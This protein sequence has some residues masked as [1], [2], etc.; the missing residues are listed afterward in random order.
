MSCNGCRALRKGCSQSCIL[1]PCLDWIDSPQAQS[2]ATL[3]V[4]KFF[5]RSDL[6][7]FIA[8]VPEKN[9]P[10]LFQSLLF[11]ACGRT[12][13]PVNGALGLLSTANWNICQIAVNTVLSGGT[14]RPVSA[15]ILT[16]Q[17]AEASDA[18]RSATK[19]YNNNSTTKQSDLEKNEI[20]ISFNSDLEESGSMISFDSG[21]DYDMKN[22]RG[23]EEPKLLNLFA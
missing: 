5:G 22:K 19:W 12:V 8:A 13:N 15:G 18:F 7:S 1:R 9:R 16:Q 23:E 14:L 20:T 17:K 21:D 6:M 10:A 3:F 2:N 11:E 4:S